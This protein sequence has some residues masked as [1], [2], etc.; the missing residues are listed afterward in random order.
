[1]PY[2]SPSLLTKKMYDWLTEPVA[3]SNGIQSWNASP[4]VPE[5]L[6]YKIVKAALDNWDEINMAAPSTAVLD[7]GDI[8]Y[9]P[10]QIHPG[11]LKY[12]QEKGV[13]T[14]K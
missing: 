9:V 7:I 8:R 14:E 3:T 4:D 10:G 2:N 13:K 1:M 12:Y 6:I 11:A 5:D